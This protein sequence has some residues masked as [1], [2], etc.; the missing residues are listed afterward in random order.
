MRTSMKPATEMR[1]T[2]VK[3]ISAAVVGLITALVWVTAFLYFSFTME[4]F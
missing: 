3:R 4:L 2:A 1:T